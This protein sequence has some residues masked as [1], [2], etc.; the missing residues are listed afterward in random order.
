MY[1]QGFSEGR[2]SH[3]QSYNQQLMKKVSNL[4]KY[5]IQSFLLAFFTKNSSLPPQILICKQ[6][7]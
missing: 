6:G 1:D 7:F 3:N 5:N 2:N 4:S